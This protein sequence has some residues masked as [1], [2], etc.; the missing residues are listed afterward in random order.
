M[1]KEGETYLDQLLNTVAPDWEDTSKQ[2]EK[3]DEGAKKDMSEDNTTMEDSSLQEAMDILN[4][5]PDMDGEEEISTSASDLADVMSVINDL[6]DME[7]EQGDAGADMDELFDL[8]A[9][10]LPETGEEELPEEASSDGEPEMTPETDVPD[11]P[12]LADASAE[13]EEA[14]DA[15]DMPDLADASAEEE[16]ASD[17]PDMPDLADAPAGEEEASDV[18]DMPDLADASAGEEE[19]SDVPDMPDLADAPTGEEEADMPDAVEAPAE[20]E[21]APDLAAEEEPEEEAPFSIDSLPE[22]DYAAPQEE[23]SEEPAVSES[24][25]AVDDIFQDALSA[26]GYSESEEGEESPDDIFSIGDMAELMDDPEE[27]VSSVPVAEPV[28]DGSRKAGKKK[29]KGPGFFKRIFGNIITDTTADEEERER[30]ALERAK[31]KKEAEK[32]EKKKQAEVNK[33]EKAQLAQEEKERKQQ[34]KAELAAKK[35]EKKEEKKRLKAE[36]AAEAAQEV[37]GKIN[38]VGATIVAIFF[39]TIGLAT[40]FGSRLLE[41]RG[42]LNDAENYFANEEYMLAYDAISSVNLK[43]DD[44][45]LYRRI[46]ICSQMQKELNSYENYTSMG[47]RLE[48]LDSLMKGIRYYDVNHAEAQNLQ[49]GTA[50]DK[51]SRQIVEKLTGDFGISEDEARTILSLEDQEEYTMQLQQLVGSN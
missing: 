1:A 8:L 9:D 32:A 25:V 13:E 28:M 34:Q 40:I 18:P 47:M 39:V 41:R 26:V 31:E 37:V 4:S 36:R 46:R 24:S 44:E 16:E 30:Q 23:V 45:T 5:L 10:T 49:I 22:E 51:L 21:A 33:E 42:S 48:A 2:P 19:A 11:M 43:E 27:G 17:A 50:Y 12:D 14:S 3:N 7:E 6:P 20:E 15:P 35:A 38:P 29:K